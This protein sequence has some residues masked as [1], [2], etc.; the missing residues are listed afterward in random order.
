LG[1]INRKKEERRVEVK[2]E[3]RVWL[4]FE[5]SVDE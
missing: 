2:E 3:E 5:C 4:V 1:K